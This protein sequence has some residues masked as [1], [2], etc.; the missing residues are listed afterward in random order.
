MPGDI[1][2]SEVDQN[3]Q[4]ELRH[5]AA[6]G[7]NR[8][9]RDLHFQLDKVANV[10]LAAY[11]GNDRTDL[12]TTSFIGPVVLSGEIGFPRPT[13]LPSG[14]SGYLNENAEIRYPKEHNL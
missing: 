1:F 10:S 12:D 8:T 2:Y 6:S 9:E 13:F 11:T 3:L 4:D 5:R 7:F 14:D